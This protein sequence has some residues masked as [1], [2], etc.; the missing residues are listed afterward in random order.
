MN[1]TLLTNPH[2]LAFSGTL[3]DGWSWTILPGVII[4]VS[5]ILN[6]LVDR[7]KKI[8]HQEEQPKR[9]RLCVD[10]CPKTEWD[11]RTPRKTTLM[12]VQ[13]SVLITPQKKATY[14]EAYTKNAY[15]RWNTN[16]PSRRVITL[17]PEKRRALEN[18]RHLKE[19]IRL[20]LPDRKDC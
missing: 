9:T 5:L 12:V 3:R 6:L 2:L 4:G 17:L 13:E 14:I 8:S 7:P 15:A 18:Q 1:Q 11:K 20:A 16:P 19:T 10:T